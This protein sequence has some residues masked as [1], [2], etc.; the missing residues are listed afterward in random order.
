LDFST[1]EL[2]DHRSY[3]YNDRGNLLQDT[4][5]SSALIFV[6]SNRADIN[7]VSNSNF[8]ADQQWEAL[9]AFIEGDSYLRA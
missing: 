5:S 6:P 1:K 9:S 2:K 3:V 7:L 4:F 8:T